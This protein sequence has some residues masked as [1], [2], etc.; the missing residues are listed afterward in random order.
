MDR[1]FDFHLRPLDEIQPWGKPA[2]NSLS[3]SWFG[4]TDGFYRLKVGE[5]FLL[6]YTPEII[7]HWTR[8]YPDT[9][10]TLI[11]YQVVRLWE[12]VLEMLPHV[13]SPLPDELIGYLQ[14]KN[15]SLTAFNHAASSWLDKQDNPVTDSPEWEIFDQATDWLRRKRRLDVFYLRHRPYIWMWAHTDTVTI[16][17]DTCDE[18]EDDLPVWSAQNGSFS[19]PRSQFLDHVHRFNDELISQMEKRVAGICREWN[20]PDIFIDCPALQREQEDRAIWLQNALGKSPSQVDWTKV[21]DA[22]VRI[23]G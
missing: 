22:V 18:T 16:T 17:W 12:D 8:K 1:L 19:M 5:E 7:S 10:S 4:F 15:L 9:K 2:D 3:L 6:N 13:L 23:C 14:T 21:M 20:R 11:D